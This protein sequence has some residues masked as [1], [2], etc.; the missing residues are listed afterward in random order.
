MFEQPQK[1]VANLVLNSYEK[2]GRRNFHDVFIYNTLFL[3]PNHFIPPIIII[4][5]SHF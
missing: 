3:D 1:S 4:F 5:L 2:L